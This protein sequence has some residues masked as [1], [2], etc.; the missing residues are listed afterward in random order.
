VKEQVY[1]HSFTLFASFSFDWS[2]LFII[3]TSLK[4]DIVMMDLEDHPFEIVMMKEE[5]MG[6][7]QRY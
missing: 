7:F 3:T 1:F 4:L 5:L 2:E 6:Y